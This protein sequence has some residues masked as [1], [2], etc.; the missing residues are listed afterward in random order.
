MVVE[1]NNKL[2]HCINFNTTCEIEMTQAI[3]EHNLLKKVQYYL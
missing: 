1:I 3:R 2:C